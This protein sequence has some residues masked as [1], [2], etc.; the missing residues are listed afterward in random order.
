[1]KWKKN[2]IHLAT[3]QI[4][5]GIDFVKVEYLEIHEKYVLI[6]Y[7]YS[8]MMIIGIRLFQTTIPEDYYQWLETLDTEFEDRLGRLIR[9]PMWSGLPKCDVGDPLKVH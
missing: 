4:G 9:G 8:C 5:G 7:I 2:Q 1:M 6:I 3:L